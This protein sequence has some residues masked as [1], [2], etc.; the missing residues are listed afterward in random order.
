MGQSARF[1][2]TDVDWRKEGDLKLFGWAESKMLLANQITEFLK[3]LTRERQWNQLDILH[4]DRDLK[5]INADL[6]DFG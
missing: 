1:L 5:K 2:H 4:F 6:K 3:E